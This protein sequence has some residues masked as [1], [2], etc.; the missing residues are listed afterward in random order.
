MDVDETNSKTSSDI[1]EEHSEF[2]SIMDT[3]ADNTDD[4]DDTDDGDNTDD[5]YIDH[6]NED[7]DE[8]AWKCIVKP[9][10][11]RHKSLF[12]EKCNEYEKDGMSNKMPNVSLLMT[13][14][15]FTRLV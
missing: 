14:I 5:D 7:Y 12:K 2:D 6:E 10:M 9:V 15:A 8:R 13:C 3:Q 1:F 11:Q 4:D